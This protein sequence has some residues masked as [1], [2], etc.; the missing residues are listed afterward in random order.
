MEGKFINFAGLMDETFPCGDHI[1]GQEL[2]L[3]RSRN[4]FPEAIDGTHQLSVHGCRVRSVTDKNIV[5]ASV[6]TVYQTGERRLICCVRGCYAAGGS[7][8]L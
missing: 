4:G 2:I 1:L 3:G 6:N 5:Q 7:L 8:S